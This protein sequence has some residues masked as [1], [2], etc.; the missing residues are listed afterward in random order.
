MR[1]RL[2]QPAM[3]LR[4]MDTELK[5]RMSPPLGLMTLAGMLTDAHDVCIE[6]ENVEQLD[7][8]TEGAIRLEKILGAHQR[9]QQQHQPEQRRQQRAQRQTEKHQVRHGRGQDQGQETGHG[10]QCARECRP[11]P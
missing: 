4:P 3:H 2:I 9:G 6:N 5:T 1:I 11:S 7:L 10:P 8:E